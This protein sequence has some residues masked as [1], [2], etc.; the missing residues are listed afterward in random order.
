MAAS[1][2][3]PAPPP[4]AMPR[5]RHPRRR[6]SCTAPSRPPSRELAPAY[7]PPPPLD[8]VG[9]GVGEVGVTVGVP[10]GNVGS[11]VGELGN[12][13]GVLLPRPR[14]GMPGQIIPPKPDCWFWVVQGLLFFF[15]GNFP[16]W[17]HFCP[18]KIG[19]RN[20]WIGRLL[21]CSD[22][23]VCQIAA[24]QVPPKPPPPSEVSVSGDLGFCCSVK[25]PTA[26]VYCG[27]APMKNAD[28]E[29]VVVP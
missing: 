6:P 12:G 14:P 19:L 3:S 23:N 28:L 26:S 2:R 7:G 9:D 4:P 25:M 1:G 11:P 20:C 21:N 22:I 15:T 29:F 18:L 16:T 5:R 24:G 8:L 10:V 17:S 27:I 13:V